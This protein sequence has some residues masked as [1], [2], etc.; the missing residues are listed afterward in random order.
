MAVGCRAWTRL[1]KMFIAKQCKVGVLN[2]KTFLDS[3]RGSRYLLDP[4][5]AWIEIDYALLLRYKDPVE[6]NRVFQ[7]VKARSKSG[8]AMVQ[9][10]IKDLESSFK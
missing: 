4:R 2:L 3:Y 7:A 9:E 6:A 1:W 8:H 10:R 5:L